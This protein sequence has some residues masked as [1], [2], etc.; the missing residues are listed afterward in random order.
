MCQHVYLRRPIQLMVGTTL[1]HDEIL[2]TLGGHPE[3]IRGAGELNIRS[4]I[5]IRAG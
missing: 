1:S 2:A 3:R 5:S 4:R